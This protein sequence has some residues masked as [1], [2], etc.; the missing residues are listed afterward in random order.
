M[1]EVKKKP[2]TPSCCHAEDSGGEGHEGHDHGAHGGGVDKLFWSML[3]L[4][5][6][7]YGWHLAGNPLGNAFAGMFSDAVFEI[8]NTMWWGVALGIVFLGLLSRV[9]R[10]L[11]MGILGTGTGVRGIFRAT[12]AGVLLDLCSHGILMVGAKL[13][14][15]GA[16]AGQVMAFLIASP[17]N[18]ISLTLVLWALIGFK[19]MFTFLVL[20]MVIGMITGLVFEKLVQREVLPQNPNRGDLPE[21]FDT[22]AEFKK[23]FT[24]MKF[25]GKGVV[26]MVKDGAMESRMVLRWL[27]LGVVIAAAMR[28]LIPHGMFEEYFGATLFGLMM[29]TILATVI[30][31]CS[32][33]TAPVAAD[34]LNRAA[35]P[36]NGFAFLMTGV[37]TDYTEIMVLR[38]ATKSWK[39]ALFLPLVTLPQVIACAVVINMV[40]V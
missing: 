10:D 9:P 33:G 30:E 38:E 32:E 25:S 11:V 19:W 34:I 1:T 17:W 13:Y 8:F 39:I 27:F 29:T 4:V 6:L 24:D 7:G 15:R 2:K 23:L 21:N 3:A 31:V 12:L 18:S 35:A 26:K 20:S 14:E 36:G 28:S 22:K 16:S 5:V 37:S 40:G